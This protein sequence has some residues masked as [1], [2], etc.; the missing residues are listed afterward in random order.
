MHLTQSLKKVPDQVESA[1]RGKDF[2]NLRLLIFNPIK[3][4]MVRLLAR[5]ENLPSI[6]S[7]RESI[8]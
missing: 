3:V 8:I 6:G 7:N 2:M 1:R 5:K 4:M